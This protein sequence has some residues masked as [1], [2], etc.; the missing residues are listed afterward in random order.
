MTPFPQS[1]TRKMPEIDSIEISPM[2]KP[3]PKPR[4]SLTNKHIT[5]LPPASDSGN[6][7]TEF[8]YGYV[9]TELEKNFKMI[10]RNHHCYP[11]LRA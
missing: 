2:K 4:S 10:F 3:V 5:T 11:D 8:D 1:I 7:P 9:I 6:E